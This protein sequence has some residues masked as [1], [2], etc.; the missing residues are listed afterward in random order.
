VVRLV[1]CVRRSFAKN[2]AATAGRMWWQILRTEVGTLIQQPT[3]AS[4]VGAITDVRGSARALPRGRGAP[5][6]PIRDSN[7]HDLSDSAKIWRRAGRLTICHHFVFAP[8]FEVLHAGT[9]ARRSSS[10]F[11]RSM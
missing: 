1:A 11:A 4:D 5:G 7:V 3:M 2:L 10:K 8:A 9:A 6:D